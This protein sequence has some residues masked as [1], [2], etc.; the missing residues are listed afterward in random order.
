MGTEGQHTVKGDAKSPLTASSTMNAVVQSKYGAAHD[1]LELRKIDKPL[2]KDDEVLVRIHAA[3]VN[4]ADAI[5]MRGVPHVVRM[6][7]GLRQPRNG[8]RG[9]DVAGKVEAVGK[10]VTQFQP[11]DEVL[12]WCEGSFAEYVCAPANNFVTKPANL[13]F[14]QAAAVPMAA[15]VALQALRDLG[16]VQPGQRVLVNGASGGIGTFTVQIAKAFGAEVTGVCSTRNVDLVR[17]IGADHVIDYT[18][19]DFTQ[20]G[21]RY[22]FVLDMVA[23]HSLSDTKRVLTPRGTFV[24]NNGTKSM[25]YMVKANLLSLLSRAP[26]SSMRQKTRTFV[27]SPKHED[28]VVLKELIEAGQ[29]TPVIDRTYPLRETPEAIDY[30]EAAHTQG[31]VVITV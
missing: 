21:Q 12:G 9:T 6:V 24:P 13:T 23:S 1:V 7:Y 5:T 27:S 26:R 29:V 31:K 4:A 19:E 17:S 2:M 16:E 15:M 30:V 18:Q 25:G 3:G 28:L 8:I 22:D 20:N 11:G 10:D 14:E